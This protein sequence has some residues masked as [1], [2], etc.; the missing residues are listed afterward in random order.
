MTLAE[1]LDQNIEGRDF[2]DCLFRMVTF[3]LQVTEGSICAVWGL[4][5]VGLAVIMGCKEAG[6]AEIYGID[7]NPAKFETGNF[8][9][10]CLFCIT[11]LLHIMK[12]TLS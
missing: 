4:G 6:A 1:C 2:P 12:C 7:I 10:I 9:I 11:I 8:N 5:A 3:S